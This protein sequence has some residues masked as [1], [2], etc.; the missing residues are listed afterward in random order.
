MSNITE[1][2]AKRAVF[3]YRVT[4]TATDALM[5]ASLF[6][7]ISLGVPGL[8][9]AI[10]TTKTIGQDFLH[11]ESLP[12]KQRQVIVKDLLV[13]DKENNDLYFA[14]LLI[15]AVGILSGSALYYKVPHAYGWLVLHYC[16]GDKLMEE[17]ISN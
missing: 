6:I 12:Q 3:L 5:I 8:I 9:R 15:I 14:S 7:G 10:N 1:A 16:I 13:K 11:I 2:E 4:K 17:E